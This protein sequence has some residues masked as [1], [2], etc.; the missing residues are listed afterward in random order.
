MACLFFK[1]R[2]T[3][4]YDLRRLA[5]IDRTIVSEIREAIEILLD[6]QELP[7]EFNDHALTRKYEGYREFHLRDTPK[8]KQPSELND[9]VVIYTVDDQNLTLIA[10]RAGAH[11]EL[12]SGSN[13]SRKYRKK[14]KTK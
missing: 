8:G 4:D 5:R 11:S 6:G 7:K 1:P 13:N 2:Q 14:Q 9:V 10:V 3:F 12:F